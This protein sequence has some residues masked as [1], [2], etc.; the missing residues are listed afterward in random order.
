MAYLTPNDLTNFFPERE[1]IELSN[2]DDATAATI[3]AVRIE[4]AIARASEEVDSYLGLRYK[5]PLEGEIPPVLQSKV[6]DVVRYYLD[7]YRTREDVVERYKDAIAWLGK[8]SK[9]QVTLGID[10]NDAP[11]DQAR[12]IG[13]TSNPAIFTMDTLGGLL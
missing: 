3:D 12:Q 9:G 5:L 4:N 2:L 10:S 11:V 7:I 6:A 13:I 1:L 8:L